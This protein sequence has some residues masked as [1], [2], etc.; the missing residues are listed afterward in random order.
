MRIDTSL[1]I[2]RFIEVH[3]DGEMDKHIAAADTQSGEVIR[4]WIDSE[5]G[6]T[7]PVPWMLSDQYDIPE[8]AFKNRGVVAVTEKPENIEV[9][10]YL[11][12]YLYIDLMQADIEIDLSHKA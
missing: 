1:P 9:R 5:N 10:L 2:S 12:K 11:D 4:H 7:N 3:I 6:G 8:G